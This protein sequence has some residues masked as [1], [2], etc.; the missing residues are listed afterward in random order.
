MR[1]GWWRRSTADDRKKKGILRP[2]MT[3][4]A[5]NRPGKRNG[6]P[7]IQDDFVAGV[8]PPV[9][10]PAT[11]EDHEGLFRCMGMKRSTFSRCTE[12]DD[13]GI[14]LTWYHRLRLTRR[15]V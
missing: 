7:L 5:H 1:N 2:G 9:H 3:E 12:E 13:H 6:I 8:L 14:V 15:S 4:T 10:S 11:I